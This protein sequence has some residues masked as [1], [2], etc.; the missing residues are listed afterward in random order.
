MAEAKKILFVED[1]IAMLNA[2]ANKFKQEGF[3]I[4]T[5]SDGEEGVKV[6]LKEKPD[7]L[8]LDIIMP[9]LDGLGV[10]KEVRENAKWGKDVPIIMLTNLS[11]P[12]HV[13]EAAKYGVYDF[14]VKTDWR[15]DEV[16]Q[17]VRTKLGI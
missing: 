14:L 2:L 12:E 10:I 16:V 13:S 5:A 9:K 6:A 17:M 3:E 7:L 15:L 8:M 11:D 1:E 4:F